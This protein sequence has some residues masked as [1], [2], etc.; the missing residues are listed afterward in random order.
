MRQS[1]IVKSLIIIVAGVA[2]IGGA[3]FVGFRHASDV[4]GD[5]EPV[6]HVLL[7][8]RPSCLTW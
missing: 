5:A 2:V 8:V 4:R 7:A 6:R 3:V 1:I